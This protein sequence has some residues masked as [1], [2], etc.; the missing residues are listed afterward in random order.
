MNTTGT[1]SPEVQEHP[2]AIPSAKRA[3]SLSLL[4]LILY[5]LIGQLIVFAVA[6][7]YR[8]ITKSDPMGTAY[9]LIQFIP[10]YLIAFPLYLLLSRPLKTSPPKK[11]KLTVGQFLCGYLIS[12]GLGVVGAFIGVFITL[13]ISWLTG[14]DYGSHF[15]EDGLSGDGA[16][17]LTIIAAFG[18][19]VVE[20]M[21]FRKILID[22]IRKY[23]NGT[24]ILL[25]GLLFGLFH[26]NFTQ[27][28]FAAMLGMFFAF[29]YIR[30]GK[31]HYTIL[32][33]CMINSLST[34]VFA[35]LLN[36]VELD[37]EKIVN[38]IRSMDIQFLRQ[39]LTLAI[40]MLCYYGSALAGIILFIVFRKQLRV[41]P[42]ETRL[43]K[44]KQFS[45]ACCNL[46]FLLF[47]LFCITLFIITAIR[48]G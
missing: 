29:I 43:P 32:L 3:Y 25:S 11:H 21:L 6:S 22:R 12:V 9:Y 47:I 1:V 45:T 39:Y 16:F 40:Y 15:L 14:Y 42:P 18:A 10:M 2:E 30:T 31:I 28:F 37:P 26:G 20:E 33:H 46:G 4:N 13:L 27:F 44:G 35:P 19:P 23:G 38:A 34:I 5:A 48:N 36:K 41:A 17:V 24:A 7:I 8:R